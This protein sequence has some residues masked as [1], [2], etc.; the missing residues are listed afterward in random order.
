MFFLLYVLNGVKSPEVLGFRFFHW[1]VDMQNDAEVESSRL[2][3]TRESPHVADTPEPI[4]F[5]LGIRRNLDEYPADIQPHLQT[6]QPIH[7]VPDASESLRNGGLEPSDVDIVVLSHVHYDH[8]GDPREFTSAQFM[9]GYGTRHLLQHGM[10]YH[11]AAKFEKD[12]L[13]PDRTIELPEP[14]QKRSHAKPIE[15]SCL[16]THGLDTLIR[17]IQHRWKAFGPFPNAMDLFGDGSIYIVDSPGHLPGHLNLLAR[18]GDASWVY[19]AGDA[20]HHPRILHGE[21]GMATWMENDMHVC[22]HSDK[23]LAED[24]VQRIAKLMREG[25]RGGDQRLPQAQA[26]AAT[27]QLHDE[28]LLT[29]NAAFMTGEW[30]SGPTL[31]EVQDPATWQTIASV[32]DLGETETTTAVNGAIQAAAQLKLLTGKQRGQLL[33]NWHRLVQQA[34]EDIA[35]VITLENGKTLAEARGEVAY[36]NDFID[37]FAGAAPRIDGAVP[38]ASNPSHRVVTVKQPVGPSPDTPLSA[39]ILARLASEAGF[40][41]G[42]LSVITSKTNTVAVGKVLTQHPAVRKFSFTGSTAVGKLLAAQCT[43][44]V[45]RVSLELG[46]NAPFLVFDDADLEKAADGIMVSKFRLAGQTCVCANRVFAQVGIYDK[47]ASL[48]VERVRQFRLGRGIDEGTTIGPLINEAAVTKVHGHVKDALDKGAR[49]LIGGQPEETLGGAFFQPTV[50]ADVPND[51]LCAREETFGP[52]LPLFKFE[53]DEDAVRLANA[54]DVGLAGYFFTKN[55]SRAWAVA[56][57]LEVGMVGVNTGII[58]D[59][60]SPFGGVKQSGLG[61]EGSSIGIDE[62][63]EVKSITFGIS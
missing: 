49:L 36:A 18:I 58:S 13:P 45:K 52:L 30:V 41:A 38:Q 8:V 46:G 19:L 2:R 4:V 43:S 47:L 32:P 50:L 57:A 5:D 23:S 55:I 53:S 48:L 3:A 17:G 44:T 62:F 42:S 63:L 31:F 60:A 33:R 54:T 25:I 28:T 24:T 15:N 20:C 35:T 37:W 26:K 16:P 1:V 21:T 39:L 40:P 11:S 27:M 9:V 7:T 10:K 14:E 61:R 51:A 59:V 29:P 12:L 22:I 56:E 34:Q 6:R